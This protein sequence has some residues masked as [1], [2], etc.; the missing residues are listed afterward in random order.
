MSINDELSLKIKLIVSLACVSQCIVD[1]FLSLSLDL[2][3]DSGHCKHI[4][5]SYNWE[6]QPL[7]LN[8]RDSLKGC[9]YKVWIDVDK[10]G[11]STLQ[12]MA[13]AVENS[14][15][16]LIAVSRKYKESANCRS[17]NGDGICH[18]VA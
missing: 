9:G 3:T 14:A 17:G 2:K 1:Y 16:I 15:V 5:I 11:G 8:I 4:M 6:Q 18:E 13:S 7:M 12:A 10:I